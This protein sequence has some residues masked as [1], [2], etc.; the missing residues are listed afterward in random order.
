MLSNISTVV[1]VWQLVVRRADT[2]Q[3]KKKRRVWF[4][5]NLRIRINNLFIG[6]RNIKHL[7]PEVERRTEAEARLASP[8]NLTPCRYISPEISLGSAVNLY[9]CTGCPRNYR[10]SILK[11]RTS[12]LGRFRDLRQYI[13]TLYV[14]LLQNYLSFDP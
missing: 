1:L 14:T 9:E 12:V 11:L 13:N 3:M 4:E 6:Q 10:K 5:K 8:V 2:D 7:V